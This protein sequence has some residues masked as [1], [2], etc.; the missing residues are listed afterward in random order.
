MLI[1]GLQCG[2]FNRTVFEELRAG[3]LG[4]VTNT[5]GFWDDAVEGMQSIADWYALERDNGDL[6]EIAYTTADIE[7]IADSGRTAIL[8]GSQ[9][10]RLIDDRLDFVETFHRLGLRVMQ[11]TYNIQNTVGGACCEQPDSGLSR[12]GRH[13]IAEMNRVGMLVDLSHVGERTC[14]DAIDA[15]AQPVAVT[16]SY[17]REFVDHPR[18]KSAQVLDALA[19]RGGVIG[20]SVYPNITGDHAATLEDW[21]QLVARLAERIGVAHIGIG[22]D[23]GRFI[24]EQDLAW[25]RQGR[26]S[27]ETEYGAGSPQAPGVVDDPDWCN[28]AS[29]LS[30]IAA[31]LERAGFSGDEV[32]EICGGNWLRVYRQVLDSAPQQAAG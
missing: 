9:N 19:A 6:V 14:L 1:D 27:R 31:G 5:I 13:V 18:N 28:N 7:R 3:G 15:S 10:S 32:E 12:F 4:C 25:M 22:S 26:W 29:Q 30:S 16:H 23:L 17:P 24:A 11:L 21:C 8:L 2:T 20:L